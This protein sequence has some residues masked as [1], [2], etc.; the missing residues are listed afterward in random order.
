[1]AA[2]LDPLPA[3]L[4]A[5]EGLRPLIARTARSLAVVAGPLPC[6]RAARDPGGHGAPACDAYPLALSLRIADVLGELPRLRRAGGAAECPMLRSLDGFLTAAE[7]GTYDPDA[8]TAA[9]EALV[10][11]GR[12]YD[13]GVL[14]ARQRREGHCGPR[15]L[16]AARALGRAPAL[17]PALRADLLSVAVRCAAAALDDAVVDD[18]LALD[19][20]TRALPDLGRNLNVVLFATELSARAGR[21]DLLAKL[22]KQ[23]AFVDR[24]MAEDADAAATALLIEAAAAALAGEP[25]P[26][27]GGAR[28]RLCG[29]PPTGARAAL[30]AQLDDL[31]AAGALPEPERR[32]RA[33][34]ALDGVIAAARAQAGQRPRPRAAPTSR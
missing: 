30:C 21:W 20:E 23:P 13:A 28:E 25:L 7:R 14:L 29:A 11:G 22:A 10:Q 3:G 31:G 6:T 33:K 26:R 19:G 15:V 34:E 12:L 32:R 24:W 27:S 18:L 2:L 5:I 8:F 17:G 1:V 16:A 9:V 4:A